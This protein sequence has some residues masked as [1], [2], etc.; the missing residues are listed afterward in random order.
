[1]IRN[2]EELTERGYARKG[3]RICRSASRFEPSLWN[4][5]S[6]LCNNRQ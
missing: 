4:R 1:M 5:L 2:Y 6:F 3:N